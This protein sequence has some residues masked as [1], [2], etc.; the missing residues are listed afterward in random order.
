MA[1]D[2][3]IAKTLAFWDIPASPIGQNHEFVAG[4]WKHQHEGCFGRRVA[5]FMNVA[6]TSCAGQ[7]SEGIRVT[8]LFKSIMKCLVAGFSK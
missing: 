1:N 6:G 8:C 2:Y 3:F 7:S 5:C 4:S